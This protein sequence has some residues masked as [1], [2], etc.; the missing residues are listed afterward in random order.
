MTKKEREELNRL[1]D[2]VGTA[3]KE[4]KDLVDHTTRVASSPIKL[5]QERWDEIFAALKRARE[6]MDTF[7]AKL[8]AG[9]RKAGL[10]V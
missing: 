2:L 1:S 7:Q 10:Q 9:A 4:L 8:E 5:T 6:R 3:Q